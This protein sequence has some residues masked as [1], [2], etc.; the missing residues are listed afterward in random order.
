VTERGESFGARLRRLRRAAGL[1]QVALAGDVLHPSYVSL[2]EADRRTPTP[3]VVD[4]LS[5]RLGVSPHELSGE[6]AVDLEEPVALA[7]AAL[8]LGRGAEAV[9]LLAPYAGRFTV[10]RCAHDPLTFRAAL[11]YATAL[12]A[13]T[14]LEPATAQLE[15]L[16]AAAELARV[17][18]FG[19]TTALVRCYRDAGDVSRAIE[20]GEAAIARHG[21]ALSG[22][23]EGHAAL[24]STLAGTYAER[25]DLLRAE[26]LLDDL[27]DRVS[28]AGSVEDEAFACWN[29]AINAVERGRPRDGLLL[30]DQA[31]TLLAGSGDARA[32]ARVTATRAWVHL[33]QQPPE[34]EQARALLREAMPMLRQYAGGHDV[35]S[36]ETE[37]ARCELALGR[38]AVAVRHARSALTRLRPENRIE[39]ARALTALGSA[40]VAGGETAAG[41]ESLGE[42]AEAL[43]AAEAPRAAAAAWR[44]LSAVYRSLGDLDRALDAADRALDGLGLPA[45]PV[46]VASPAPTPAQRTRR[47]A[48]ADG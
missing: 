29:A 39:R 21:P 16:S 15:V 1:T 48:R 32:R 22:R 38:P 19:V 40:L 14:R 5:A 28:G 7:E 12:E 44:Q 33:S 34:A 25:G 4:A 45:E 35:A 11:A 41:V 30:A 9:D 3:D 13:C 27:L 46:P 36:A 42:A 2:L 47:T 20:V 43:T 6:V 24:V 26:L 8:G 18:A 17:P 37:L 31:A 10:E 23:I